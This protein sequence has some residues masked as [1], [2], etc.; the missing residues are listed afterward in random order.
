MVILFYVLKR[1]GQGHQAILQLMCLVTY[2]LTYFISVGQQLGLLLF[3][4]PLDSLS[5]SPTP[6]P[7]VKFATEG[8]YLLQDMIIIKFVGIK[9]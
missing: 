3:Y 4:L 8:N 7:G 1:S 6:E 5:A 9:N 2:A